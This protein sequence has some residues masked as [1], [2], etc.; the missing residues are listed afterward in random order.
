MKKNVFLILF[1]LLA[2]I[3]TGSIVLKKKQN[4]F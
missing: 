2:L 4:L 1:V 3:V